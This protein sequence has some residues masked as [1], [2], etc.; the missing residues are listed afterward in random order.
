MVQMI[1][2]GIALGAIY[3][4]VA[5]GI[6]LV[7]KATGILNF[8][9]GEMVMITTFVALSLLGF[10]LPYWLAVLLTL[11]FAAIFGFA[12]ETVLVRK[13]IGAPLLSTALV[14]LGLFLILGDVSVWIWGKDAHMFPS[15]FSD[16]PF[17]IGQ[18]SLS[19]SDLGP[20]V[21]CILLSI[22]LY[23]FFKL[24]KVGIAMQATID[25]QTAAKLMG[26]PVKRM[27]ALSW[28]LATVVAAIAGLLIAPIIFLHF[29]FM[30]SILHFAFAAAVLGGINS[31]SGAMI[32]GVILG[33]ITN[34]VGIYLSS[35]L[36]EAM[37]FLIMLLILICKP[38]GLFSREAE[39]KV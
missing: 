35:E 19:P 12:V 36:K 29:T 11:V 23:L 28:V 32:G 3:G 9:H 13:L 25:N 18:V 6:V 37:P 30:Q 5:L 17:T 39:K 1:I 24:T 4:L 21:V 22:G 27:F 8:A 2:S 16:K 26:I 20:I 7:H 15:P 10:G 31:L 33:V 14:C 34:L 38:Q